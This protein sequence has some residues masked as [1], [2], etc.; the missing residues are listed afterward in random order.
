MP[1]LHALV[2]GHVQGVGFRW[3]VRQRARELGLRGWV[4]N[5][6]DGTVEVEAEGERSALERLRGSL[7]AGPPGAQVASVDELPTGGGEPE[8]PHPFA[9]LR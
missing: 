4:R 5:R 7:A 3:F 1:V 2:R 6:S 9:I 8:L